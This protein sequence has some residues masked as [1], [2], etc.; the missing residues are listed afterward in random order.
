MSVH[1]TNSS[2]AYIAYQQ[3]VMGNHMSYK[4]GTEFTNH[5]QTQPRVY[6]LWPIQNAPHFADDISEVILLNENCI[7]F[8]QVRYLNL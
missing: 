7:V 2:G 3:N 6:T 1:L 5:N 8:E 4:N